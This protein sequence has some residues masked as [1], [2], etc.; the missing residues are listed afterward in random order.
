MIFAIDRTIFS[1]VDRTEK[2]VFYKHADK[3]LMIV[4]HLTNVTLDVKDS[5]RT[6]NIIQSNLELNQPVY[7]IVILHKGATMTDEAQDFYVNDPFSQEQTTALAVV[8]EQ[9]FQRLITSAYFKIKQPKVPMSAFSSIDKAM[10]WL[11]EKGM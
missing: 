10:I 3:N 5:K 9:L 8:F 7:G 6:V 1:E 4:E 2:S 11:E